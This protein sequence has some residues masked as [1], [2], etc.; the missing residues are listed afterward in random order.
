M[1]QAKI[2]K[3][4]IIHEPGNSILNKTGNWRVMKPVKDKKK[5]TNCSFCWMFCPD[6]AINEKF[7]IN[8]EYCKGC[9][10]CAKACPFHAI[11]MEQEQK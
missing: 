3:A 9:G 4:A 11:T 6:M 2:S 1:K 7:E 5:C 8:Y 10:I